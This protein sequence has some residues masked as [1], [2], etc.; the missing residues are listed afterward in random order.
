ML[1][2]DVAFESAGSVVMLLD[3]LLDMGVECCMREK[4][5]GKKNVGKESIKQR[6]MNVTTGS[7]ELS[8]DRRLQFLEGTEEV[9][10][11]S[12]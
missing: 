10:A 3:V 6:C 1:W 2:F 11:L 12:L 4:G 5:G 7:S 8:R 9:Q